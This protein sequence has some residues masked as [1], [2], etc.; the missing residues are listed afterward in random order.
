MANNTNVQAVTFD[1]NYARVGSANVVSC[2]L[3]MKRVL[4]VWT[5]QSIATVIP[6]DANTLIDGAATDGRPIVLD[7]QI[8]TMIAN[9]TTLVATFE[10]NSNLILNQFLQVAPSGSSVVQ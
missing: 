3:T 6:N 5:G 8:Q 2:Y 7:S 10:A 1:N 4:Q 9:M